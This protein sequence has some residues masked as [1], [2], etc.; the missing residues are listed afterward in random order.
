MK[1]GE[2]SEMNR[3]LDI[4]IE[5]YGQNDN[6]FVESAFDLVQ[7]LQRQEPKT[8]EI[9]KF[10]ADEG[11]MS[12]VKWGLNILNAHMD[13]CEKLILKLMERDQQKSQV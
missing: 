6:L 3:L 5:Q 13:I 12:Q 4:C 7:L 8:V 10:W 2:A 1:D 9:I 11:N